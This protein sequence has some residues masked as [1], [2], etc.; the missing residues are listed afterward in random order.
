[1]T[2]SK[3]FQLKIDIGGLEVAVDNIVLV[4]RRHGLGYLLSD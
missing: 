4:C 3:R 1:M 2:A